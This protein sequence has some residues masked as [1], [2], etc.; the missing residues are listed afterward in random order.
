MCNNEIYCKQGL[1]SVSPKSRE[2]TCGRFFNNMHNSR[3]GW[4]RLSSVLNVILKIATLLQIMSLLSID[5][6]SNSTKITFRS[7]YFR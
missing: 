5:F 7:T 4:S 1:G 2:Y 3:S 6:H